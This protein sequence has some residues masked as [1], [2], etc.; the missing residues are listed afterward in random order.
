MNLRGEQ[1]ALI[2][3]IWSEVALVERASAL[4]NFETILLLLGLPKLDKGRDLYQSA[5]LLTDLRNALMHYKLQNREVGLDPDENA[6]GDKLAQFEKG[7]GG[8]F[9]KNPLTRKG[10]PLFPD[11]MIGHGTAEWSV[12]TAVAFLDGFCQSLSAMPP[13]EHI[14]PTFATR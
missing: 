11:R 12:N 4:E 5:S 7:L 8:R 2:G 9:A 13:Y 1:A 14:R 6:S 3:R 10:N